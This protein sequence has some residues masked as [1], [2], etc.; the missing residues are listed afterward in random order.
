MLWGGFV[1]KSSLTLL[2]GEASAG[3]SVFLFR[4]A[5][6][7]AKG[8]EFLGISPPHPLKILHV[9]LES[10]DHLKEDLLTTIDPVQ[11]WDFVQIDRGSVVDTLKNIKDEFDLIIVDSLQVASPVRD[12]N[13]NAEANR[14]I[15]SYVDIARK[16]NTSIILTHNA[17]IGNEREIF[18]A[19]GASARVDRSDVVINFDKISE[20]TRRLKIV[21]SRHGNLGDS[22]EFEFAEDLNYRV[23]RGIIS[24]PTKQG[25]MEQKI[26]LALSEMFPVGSEIVRKELIEKLNIDESPSE[27]R[28]F[29]RA[30]K[31]LVEHGNLVQP[32]RG[33]Y[34]LAPSKSSSDTSDSIS[35]PKE[36]EPSG[37]LK[38]DEPW[39]LSQLQL[40]ERS[41]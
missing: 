9:D 19:R 24:P 21:K 27:E 25:K 2:V 36:T 35:N 40:D 12:E 20:R 14:Q 29:E 34:S 22:L 11:G 10:P 38:N 16:K 23:T 18:K 39:W 8:D 6:S 13:D 4:L 26:I 5:S 30:L 33:I 1:L 17:G 3:K 41:P 7:L 32:R 37:E 15:T 28:M 31:R